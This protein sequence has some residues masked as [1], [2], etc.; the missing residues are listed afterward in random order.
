MA[1]IKIHVS[2]LVTKH[3]QSFVETHSSVLTGGKT[4]YFARIQASTAEK[5]GQM[6]SRIVDDKLPTNIAKH[7]RRETLY[8][9]VHEIDPLSNEVYCQILFSCDRASLK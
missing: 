1:A 4:K 8:A 7:P 2:L 5:M 9:R 3:T 6:I